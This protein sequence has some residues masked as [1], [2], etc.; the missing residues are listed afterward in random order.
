MTSH[1]IAAPVRR[2]VPPTRYPPHQAAHA[3]TNPQIAGISTPAPFSPIMRKTFPINH[4]MQKIDIPKRGRSSLGEKRVTT[5]RIQCLRLFLFKEV[6]W[7]GLS[8]FDLPIIDIVRRTVDS[9]PG[10]QMQHR[11]RARQIIAGVVRGDREGQYSIRIND[12]WRI[13]FEWPDRSLGPSNVRLSTTTR[14]IRY[15]TQCNPPG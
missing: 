9:T 4:A 12:Q 10:Q 8:L 14:R 3:K 11:G 5:D 15:G 13:C 1:P 6:A 2:F 7:V